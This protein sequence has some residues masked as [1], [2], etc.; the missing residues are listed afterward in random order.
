MISILQIKSP[1]SITESFLTSL[2]NL[3]EIFNKSFVV[4]FIYLKFIFVFILFAIGILTL[5]KLR[6]ICRME[7]NKL[8]KSDS[9]KNQLK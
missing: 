7:R 1:N 2:E 5:T 3:W 6:G 8:V 9:E 4:F